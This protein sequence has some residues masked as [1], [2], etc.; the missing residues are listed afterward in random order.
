MAVWKQIILIGAGAVAVLVVSAACIKV[1]TGRE[2]PAG[3]CRAV[4]QAVSRAM[5]LNRLVYQLTPP[6][7]TTAK[8]WDVSCS[9]QSDCAPTWTAAPRQQRQDRPNGHSPLTVPSD[10]AYTLT[11][12]ATAAIRRALRAHTKSTKPP[13]LIS[14]SIESDTLTVL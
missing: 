6:R 9:P 10:R 1:D 3:C 8:G 11:T 7:P 5:D 12:S 13:T 2:A 14:A 4:R